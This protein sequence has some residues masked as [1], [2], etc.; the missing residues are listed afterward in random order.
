MSLE[1]DIRKVTRFYLST[2]KNKK[3]GNPHVVEESVDKFSQELISQYKKHKINFS[4]TDSFY[5]KR[6]DN[7]EEERPLEISLIDNSSNILLEVN[8]LNS[9]TSYILEIRDRY[10]DTTVYLNY[11]FNTLA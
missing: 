2:G 9:D 1:T 8:D 4:K 3:T 10:K 7:L 6:S 5:L 11:A